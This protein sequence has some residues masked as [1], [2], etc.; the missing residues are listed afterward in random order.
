M[1][2]GNE[3]PVGYE[4]NWAWENYPMGPS[5]YEE[6]QG[7]WENS[8]DVQPFSNNPSSEV[9][10]RVRGIM[11]SF[12]FVFINPLKRFL[13]V[14]K[15]RRI[16]LLCIL[17]IILAISANQAKAVEIEEIID[18]K[19]IPLEENDTQLSIF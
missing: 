19:M 10:A 16:N 12:V 1:G 9:A 13:M 17:L 18:N 4:E 7:G 8:S 11:M 5:Y 2:T 6:E 14:S 3:A 15:R